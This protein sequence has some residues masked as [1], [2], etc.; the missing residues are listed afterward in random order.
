MLPN[1]ALIN[2]IFPNNAHIDWS[3][4]IV[5][6]PYITGLVAGAFVV[7]SLYHVFRIEVFAP[8]ARFALIS[9]FCFGLFAAVPL[10]FHLGQP[11][12]A[13]NIFFGMDDID[14]VE[15]CFEH[16][17]AKKF[18]DVLMG[19]GACNSQFEP[20]YAPAGGHSA[21]WWPFA[22]YAVGGDPD[23]WDRDREAYTQRLL[24]VWREYAMNLDDD[25]VRAKFLF[26]PLDI[27][28]LNVNMRQGAVRMGD[29]W[30]SEDT[31]S[32]YE[33]ALSSWSE[34]LAEDADLLLYGCDL[35][36][37]EGEALIGTEACCGK[38]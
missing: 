22:P 29:A 20:S 6:Y 27:E 36:A 8:M 14:Q 31:L 34:A 4:M 30:L 11:Q 37:G 25:N 10:L 35:A 19:N 24:E 3:M 16:C 1:E 18:P 9:A 21:F 38:W 28:R 17:E 15:Q 5:I 33:A 2:F 32:S 23:N 7:S 26:T 12:R 13:F